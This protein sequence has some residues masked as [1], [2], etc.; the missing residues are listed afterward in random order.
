MIILSCG[1]QMYV[2]KVCGR[3][4]QK[5]QSLKK[6]QTKKKHLDI[7]DTIQ[8]EIT[9]VKMKQDSSFPLVQSS[10]AEYTGGEPCRLILLQ[11]NST[12]ILINNND[13]DKKL[14]NSPDDIF[15][16][17]FKSGSQVTSYTDT[18]SNSVFTTSFDNNVC[19]EE[20]FS[21]NVQPYENIQ[22][23]NLISEHEQNNCDLNFLEPISIDESGFES[24][25][26]NEFLTL[27]NM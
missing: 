7:A 4:Y 10:S 16:L 19:T 3:N 18:T 2:C 6:H 11:P 25:F 20:Y 14:I 21:N 12:I 24:F 17:N 9:S 15:K 5:E 27:E 26:S 23:D 13:L 8:R 22:S 1:K